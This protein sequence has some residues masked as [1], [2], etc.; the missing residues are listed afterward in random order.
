[1][2]AT[3]STML[4][5]RNGDSLFILDLLPSNSDVRHLAVPNRRWRSTGA[6]F[7]YSG[8]RL[9]TESESTEKSKKSPKVTHFD[10]VARKDKQRGKVPSKLPAFLTALL[11]LS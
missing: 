7:R 1:M 11:Y 9:S 8:Y 5:I 4:E 6:E 10:S 2:D 3:V